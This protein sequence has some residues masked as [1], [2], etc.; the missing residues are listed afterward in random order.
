[1]RRHPD[2]RLVL[3]ATVV[4]ALVSLITTLG[5]IRAVFA[6]PLALVLPGY[7]ITAAVCGRRRLNWAQLIPLTLGVSLATL[8][9]L[10]IVLN[11]T[12][13]GIRGLPWVFVLVAVVLGSCRAAAVRRGRPG[14]RRQAWKPRWPTPRAALLSVGCLTTVAMALILAQTTLRA[15]NLYGY[16]ELWLVPTTQQTHPR[17]VVGVRSEAEH[18]TSYRLVATLGGGTPLV[19]EFKL[20]PG[21]SRSFEFGYRPGPRTTRVRAELY[22]RI[23]PDSVYRR[24]SGWLPA[25]RRSEG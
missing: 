19:H 13:G 7:S 11:Y 20:E 16:S 8:V 5:A 21:Q 4:C 25:A 18:R 22:R 1:M 10:S 14:R 2:L 3:A 12:P 24:V 15:G 9:L 6:V 17:A 23:A